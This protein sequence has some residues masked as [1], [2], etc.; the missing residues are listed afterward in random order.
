VTSAET[1]D[2]VRN[3]VTQFALNPSIATLEGAYPM[4]MRATGDLLLIRG[5]PG[6]SKRAGPASVDAGTLE[7]M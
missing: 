1:V 2:S 3:Q 5:A 6:Q 7:H 4:S